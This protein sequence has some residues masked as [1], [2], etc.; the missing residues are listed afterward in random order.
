MEFIELLTSS[1]VDLISYIRWVGFDEFD[2]E[3]K[4]KRKKKREK[5]KE[6]HTLLLAG[7]KI[8]LKSRRRNREHYTLMT[9]RP[10]QPCYQ[11]IV[12]HFNRVILIIYE[13]AVT[14]GRCN[15]YFN[16]IKHVIR[17]AH[18]ESMDDYNI[19][20]SPVHYKRCA[21]SVSAYYCPELFSC[22]YSKLRLFGWYM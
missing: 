10:A 20:L 4:K 21:T 17:C 6:T 12:Y 3:K 14:S 8:D 11:F 1:F 18:N 5:K 2:L 22:L 9:A 15:V 16:F 19:N 7:W 13:R